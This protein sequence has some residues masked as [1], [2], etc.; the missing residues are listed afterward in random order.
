MARNEKKYHFIYKTTNTV[1]GHYYYGLHSTDN[2]DDGYLG[3][4]RRLRYSINKYSKDKHQREI[5]EFCSDRCS[6]KKRESELVDLNEVAKRDCMNLRVG[7]EGGF[8]YEQQ[9]INSKKGNLKFLELME[10][11]EWRKKQCNK[12][13]IAQ[14]EYCGKHGG[15]WEGKKHS[16]E[17]KKKIG[18]TNSL[19]LKGKGNSQY[20]TC[21]IT[22]GVENKKTKRGGDI[23][24]GWYQGR[25]IKIQREN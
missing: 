6:L 10:D 13:S 24:D 15:Y 7:G 4:G 17:T 14:K 2:L 12:I 11:P 20:G 9:L 22:N 18:K 16:D 3:S 1:T 8:S 19:K 21:W 5:I 25:I 23:P